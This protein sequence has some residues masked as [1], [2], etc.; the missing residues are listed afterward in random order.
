MDLPNFVWNLLRAVVFT[1]TVFG[2]CILREKARKGSRKSPSVR[3]R[4]ARSLVLRSA[5]NERRN[6]IASDFVVAP[7]DLEWRLPVVSSEKRW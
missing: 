3:L 6:A 5:S 1:A 7:V 2:V 4:I